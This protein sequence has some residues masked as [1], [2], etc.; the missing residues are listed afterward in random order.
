MGKGGELD[1]P[2]KDKKADYFPLQE[3]L[4]HLIRFES[5]TEQFTVER[6]AY[7]HDSM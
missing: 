3:F 2:D 5:P 1:I 7:H 6:G 4:P